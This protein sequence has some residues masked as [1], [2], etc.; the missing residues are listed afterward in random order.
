MKNHLKLLSWLTG[1]RYPQR[2]Q[3]RDDARRDGQ[4]RCASAIFNP[5][6]LNAGAALQLKD[7]VEGSL[8]ITMVRSVP[9]TL[10]ATRYH[11]ADG[12]YLLS[13]REFAGSIRLATSAP[14][15][16]AMK[17]IAPDVIF[18]GRQAI[19]DGD[20]AQVGP[21]VA[22]T[23]SSAGDHAEEIL[24][25]QGGCAGYQAPPG[26]WYGGCRMPDS[27]GRYGQCRLGCRGARRATPAA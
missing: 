16:C 7:R 25:S 19:D 2:G 20:T 4:P 22:R 27:F 8:S 24:E 26:A 1:S 9:P 6:D 15:L 12:G 11:G 14:F 3:G 13:G 17:K 10:S 5:E 18:A 23:R 21:Q